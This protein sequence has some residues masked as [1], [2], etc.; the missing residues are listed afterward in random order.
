[1]GQAKGDP[2]EGI[3]ELERLQSLVLEYWAFATTWLRDNALVLSN[4]AQALIVGIAFVIARLLDPACNRLMKRAE[5][6]PVFS[7]KYLAQLLTNLQSLTLPVLWLIVQWVS[8]YLAARAGW[9]THLLRGVVS[10]LTAWV[11]IRLVTSLVGNPGLSKFIAVLA[12]TVAALNIVGLLSPTMALLDGLAVNAGDV[13]ISVLG[14]IKAA[15]M[16]AV[17]L[18]GASALSRL[19]ERWLG[20]AVALSPSA[21][22]L[23]GKLAKIVL[24]TV[25]VILGLESV[26]IDLTAFAVFSGALGLGIGFGLQKVFANLVSGVILLLD[27]SVK[28]GDVIAVSGTYGWINTLSARYVS[29][30]TRDG[31]EHLI[32]NEELISQKVENWSYSNRRVRLRMPIGVAYESDVPRAMELAVEAATGMDRV[33]SNPPPVCQLLGFGDNAVDLELRAWIQ[34]PQN[35]VANVKSR[36]LLQVWDLFHAHGIGFPFPQRD[37]HVRGTVP[38]RLEAPAPSEEAA[39]ATAEGAAAGAAPA[40]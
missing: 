12:W 9:P 30:V 36:I 31:I 27:R 28:P 17:L 25:A 1:M 10:L 38:V 26:G 22:V 37:L 13:R 2:L 33:L 20:K 11:V 24:I 8:V 23:F 19:V 21:Q 29:V 18:W 4:L 40:D 5:R 32:P 39:E 6:F 34:D 7:E 14:L 3:P 16:L 35:G 15:V